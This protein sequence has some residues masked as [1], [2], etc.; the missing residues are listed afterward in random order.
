[1]GLRYRDGWVKLDFVND[2]QTQEVEDDGA[3]VL[4]DNF[5]SHRSV[6]RVDD[7]EF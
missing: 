1:M 2:T 5:F 6:R 4:F 3:Y 7:P